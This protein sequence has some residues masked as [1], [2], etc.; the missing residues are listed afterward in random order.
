MRT[1]FAVFDDTVQETSLWLGAVQA[2]LPS[3]DQGQAYTALRAVLHVL[4]DRLP[5]AGVLGL[6]MQLPH[7]LRGIA[8][9]GWRPHDGLSDVRDVDAFAAAVGARLPD[10]FPRS[11]SEVVQ[12]V[13]AVIAAK[14]APEDVG[15]IPRLLPAP[16][17]TTWP[18]NAEVV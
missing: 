12:T 1:G 10:N 3:C 6:S 15:K 2:G 18:G 16:L 14:L 11:A 17:R 13:L 8:L 4:R 7:L 9:E 5:L